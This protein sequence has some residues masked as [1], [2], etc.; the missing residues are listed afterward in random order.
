MSH[1]VIYRGPDGKPGYQQAEDIHDAVTFVEQMRNEEGVEQA[2]IFRLEEVVFEY[3]P[4]YRVELSGSGLEA[5]LEEQLDPSLVTASTP[6]VM[7]GVSADSSDMSDMS[8]VSEVSDL[9]DVADVSDVSDISEVTE[10]S[11][12]LVAAVDEPFEMVEATTINIDDPEAEPVGGNG[13]RRGL[14]GR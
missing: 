5:G 13:A 2:R 3:R 11:E 9:T 8:D 1:M 12:E 6:M 10:A 7:A 4:Y 14:F